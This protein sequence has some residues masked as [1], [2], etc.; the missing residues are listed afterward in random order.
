[1]RLESEGRKDGMGWDGR[2]E[3]EREI[4]VNARWRAD[5][6]EGCEDGKTTEMLAMCS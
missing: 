4:F 5:G 1:M 2:N 3:G 6:Y